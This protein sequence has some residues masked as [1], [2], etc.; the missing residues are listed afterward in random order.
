GSHT[1]NWIAGATVPLTRQ[2]A[3]TSA[4]SDCGP[5]PA[6]PVAT[7]NGP[8]GTR[9]AVS[10]TVS[11]NLRLPSAV[12]ASEPCARALSG[13]AV[14]AAATANATATAAFIGAPFSTSR[15]VELCGAGGREKAAPATARGDW[16]ALRPLHGAAPVAHRRLPPPESS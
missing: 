1:S 7:V 14:K 11:G 9:S 10:A 16:R 3:G 4:E 8:A 2:N 15:C 6:L 13:A 5:G 12:H